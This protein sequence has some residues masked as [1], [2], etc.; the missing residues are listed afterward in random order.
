MIV[1]LAMMTCTKANLATSV[2]IVTTRIH[3]NP[4]K[5]PSWTTL[6]TILPVLPY[7]V[8]TSKWI[9]ALVTSKTSLQPWHMISAWT[10]TKIITKGIL[11]QKQLYPDCASCHKETG[12][13][14]STFTLEQHEKSTFALEG[15]HQATPCNACHMKE[16]KW[17]FNL[18]NQQCKDCHEDIH[19]A[20]MDVRYYGESSCKSCHQTEAWS[21]VTFDHGSTGWALEGKHASI[22]CAKCHFEEKS[23]QRVQ[24]FRDLETE[25]VNCHDNVHGD[26]F[27][28]QGA[29]D[30]SRCH[31]FA[32]WKPNKFDHSQT[33][34]KLE[35]GHEGL[36]CIKCHKETMVDGKLTTIYKIEKFAC[37]DCHQ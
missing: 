4:V 24:K 5:H 19:Q 31:G 26:Q 6:I 27:E 36:A 7:W 30:C 16:N 32:D 15:A 18:P 25:C 3:L 11:I 9:V 14:P 12:F 8:N 34:F 21:I 22:G 28:Q 33:Q 1:A 35:G 20:Y 10:V 23:G 13:M 29:T 17:E 37:V 2:W